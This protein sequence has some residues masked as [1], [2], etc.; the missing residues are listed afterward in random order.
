[1]FFWLFWCCLFLFDVL[2]SCGVGEGKVNKTIVW[3]HLLKRLRNGAWKFFGSCWW[4]FLGF[5]GLFLFSSGDM[6]EGVWV[7]SRGARRSVEKGRNFSCR[8]GGWPRTINLGIS[9]L[10]Y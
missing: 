5:F 8:T 6:L 10:R 9:Q 4:V 2:S 1:M 3:R 7:R